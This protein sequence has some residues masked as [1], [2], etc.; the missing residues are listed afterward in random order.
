M[1][2]E[3]LS[4]LKIHKLTQA[5][6]DRELAAGRIEENAL[7]LTPE[8]EIDLSGYATID[9]V[10][11]EIRK[12]PTSDVEGQIENHNVDEDAHPIIL[13]KI[14]AIT[15]ENIGA[16]ASGHNHDDRY[17]DK[18]EVDTAISAIT[19]PVYSVNGK[20][21]AVSLTASDV[22]AR[23]NTWVPNAYDV[24][25]VPV[26]R[27]I[28]GHPL[29]SDVVLSASDVGA[30]TTT[31]IDSMLSGKS[32]TG[33][34]H[35]ADYDEKGAAN[36]ALDSAKA[37][38][39]SAATKVK[40]DLLN[41][42]GGAYDT[43]KELGDLIDDNRDAI[44]A[45]E[46]VAASKVPSD[47]TVNGKAL[48]SNITLSASDV[49]AIPSAGG[50]VTGDLNFGNRTKG[51]R[52]TTDDG[53]EFWMRPH[54]PSNLFQIAR[55]DPDGTPHATFNINKE[56]Q[57]SFGEKALPIGSGGTGATTAAAARTNLGITPANIGASES[58]HTH[59]YAGSASAGGAATSANKLNTNAGSATQPVYFANGVPVNTTYTLGKSVP[60]DAK[61]TDTV[62]THPTYTSKSSGLYKIT[63]D[64]TG[65]VSGATAVTKA[66]ITA[67]G[68]PAQ[69]TTY[70]LGSF[71]LTATATELN[72][73]DGV[74]SNIQ[75]QLNGKAGS[76]HTHSYVTDS[77]DSK[78][79]TFA[80]SKS[81]L[82]SASWVAGWNGYELRAITP[83]NVLS[84][85]GVTA[86]VAE[87]NYCDGVTSN[88]QTQLNGKAA[89]S[90]GTHVTYG[91]S[92][93]ALGTS[94]AGSAS[95]VSRS[96]HVHALPALTSCTGTLT[97]AKGGTGSNNGATG[98]KNLF[99]AGATILSSHQYG[100]ALPSSGTAGQIF[101][102][103]DE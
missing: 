40:N 73:C 72:Y 42:A 63:V 32:D 68:I 74:T 3:N 69:D 65:H 70:N 79:I 84:S 78:S 99:A 23:S 97:V 101:F 11:N 21:G 36:D 8:E 5:Q 67:L 18:T 83:A 87:L 34:N 102:L 17:Y 44:D 46:I 92:A 6:Y 77:G 13:E 41:N 60:S 93:S 94:S 71:G 10:D 4:T 16:A 29:S 103:L 9:Y 81:G 31:E 37:Y 7:Y 2:T 64:G 66:D 15:P 86:S 95:T 14:N 28:N 27:T 100:S 80:Y 48:S 88:I 30:Y 85:A 62:Y 33:H 1:N 12:I 56:G 57:V 59:N 20:T 35:D 91:T 61:F 53:T 75:T 90:H 45:L 26:T 49:G 47:R 54:T 22:G 51:I 19:F 52:W 58:G 24:N 39:D 43:L 89:S 25:A 76:G 55:F 98:L 96:D 82:S 50:E 38:A